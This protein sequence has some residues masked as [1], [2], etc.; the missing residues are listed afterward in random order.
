MLKIVQ[1]IVWAV[2]PLILYLLIL[3]TMVLMARRAVIQA[4]VTRKPRYTGVHSSPQ[5]RLMMPLS[6]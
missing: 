1:H 6:A 3:R 5:P 2:S 4:R